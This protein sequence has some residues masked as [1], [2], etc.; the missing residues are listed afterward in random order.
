MSSF[1]DVQLKGYEILM[2]VIDICERNHLTYYLSSGTLLGAIRHDGFIPWDN[3]I[4][5][6]MPLRD[7]RKFIKLAKRELPDNL[8]LQTYHTDPGYN[9]MWAKVRANDTAS[10]PV[11]W[12]NY[13]V[14]M[15]IGIDIFPLV[16]IYQNP[17]LR[18]WQ[19]WLHA[20]CRTLLAKEY[21]E[22]VRSP[23]L[24]SLK[25]R[26][27]FAIPRRIRTAICSLLEHYT[28][29]NPQKEDEISVAFCGINYAVER[30]AYGGGRKKL[31]ESREFIIP[32]DYDHVLTRLYGDYMTP[33]PESE[34]NGH[35]GSHGKII[36]DCGRSYKEYLTELR[37]GTLAY[38]TGR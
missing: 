38:D 16:G 13:N 19:T 2:Q 33:P 18:K 34:R 28:F 9:E 5:I 24:N 17:L 15:G 7:Y 29:R 21:L 22:A 3:D 25:L 31:F 35:E 30:R 20:F 12:E 23:E 8:F 36:Y 10:I 4:D 37:E 32:E 14:H 27:L 11:M 1:R 26:I 6:E